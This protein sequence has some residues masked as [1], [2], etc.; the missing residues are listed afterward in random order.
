MPAGD[1]RSQHAIGM[2]HADGEGVAKDPAE[3]LK[4][5]KLAAAQ[6]LAIAQGSLGDFYFRGDIPRNAAEGVK[7][8]RL[9]A[10]Q[11]DA[12]ARFGLALSYASGEALPQDYAETVKWFRL[13]AAQGHKHAQHDL[14]RILKAGG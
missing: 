8:L 1:V 6:G 5:L 12:K 9:A 4:W 13:A 10:D 11:G 2:R 7:W 14:A 3:A